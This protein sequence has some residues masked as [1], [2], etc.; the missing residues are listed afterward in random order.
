MDFDYKIAVVEDDRTTRLLLQ[1][2]L[3]SHY[4]LHVVESAEE[5]LALP[6]RGGAQLF[7]LD[8]GLPGMDGLELC[9]ALKSDPATAQAPVMFLSGH[10]TSE[11][12]LAGYEAG[13]QDYIVKPFDVASLRHKIENLQRIQAQQEILAEQVR[14][15]DELTTQVLASLDEY[16]V[17]IK[18]LRT[19]NECE[20]PDDLIQASLGALQGFNLESAVQIR[21]QGSEKTCSAYGENWPLEVAVINHIR[22]LDRIFEH[23]HLAAFNFDNITML[24]TNMPRHEFELCGRIRD[25]LAIAMESANAKIRAMQSFMENSWM[26]GEIGQILQDIGRAL[27]ELAQKYQDARYQETIYTAHFIDEITSTFAEVGMSQQQEDVL[28]ESVRSHIKTFV[29]LYDIAPHTQGTLQVLTQRMEK[30]LSS[31]KVE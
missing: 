31:E 4:A 17:L 29:D 21:M 25:H 2:S 7:L 20:T 6:D 8:V 27:Q 24:V 18:F 10:D 15:A 22:T 3:G 14:N 13:G 16:A 9:R 1:S 5:L 19:L 30:I 23:K 28:L 11:E 26:R 12:I